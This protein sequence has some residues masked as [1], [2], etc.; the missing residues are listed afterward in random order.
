ML[1]ERCRSWL[2]DILFYTLTPLYLLL[3]WP[4]IWVL[5]RSFTQ[6]LFYIW[7]GSIVWGLRVVVGITHRVIG[8]EHLKAAQQNGQPVIVASRHESAWDTFI[9]ARYVGNFAIVLKRDLLYV[10]LFGSYL[11]RLGSIAVDRR[12]VGAQSIRHVRDQGKK[13]AEDG[14]SILI[15][16]EGTRCEP[17]EAKELQP[18]V[19]LLSQQLQV[20]VVPVAHDAG[21]CWGR[22]AMWKRPGVITLRFHPAIESGLDRPELLA[23]LGDAIRQV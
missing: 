21:A 16:P 4:W 3:F 13:A 11:K 6:K 19:A 22:R 23:K 5:P 20:P 15:F 8:L 10:P 9:F 17:G 1:I 12:K 14:L 2:F 18:G 7:V